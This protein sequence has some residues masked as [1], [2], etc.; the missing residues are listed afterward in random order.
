VHT[1]KFSAYF[2]K[3]HGLLD[4]GR[5]VTARYRRDLSRRPAPRPHPATLTAVSEEVLIRRAEKSDLAL[6]AKLAAQLV[7]MHHDTDPS[8]FLLVDRV[9]E[10][11]RSSGCFGSA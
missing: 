9:K 8:R 7:R 3:H 1:T 11:T 5:G 4:V 6:V 10:A 2:A